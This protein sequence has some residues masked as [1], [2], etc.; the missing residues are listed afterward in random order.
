MTSPIIVMAVGAIAGAFAFTAIAR[1]L[2]ARLQTG[3]GGK[4]IFAICLGMGVLTI[5]VKA[6]GLLIAEHNLSSLYRPSHVVPTSTVRMEWERDSSQT[7]SWKAL[8]RRDGNED[9]PHLVALGRKLFSDPILSRDGRI[10]CASCH[11]IAHGGDDGQRVS[12]GIADRAGTRNAPSV[13]NAALLSRQF[14]DGRAASLEEQVYGP[15]LNPIEMGMPDHAAVQKAL[16]KDGRYPGLFRQAFGEDAQPTLD[17]AAKAIAA[18]ERTLVHES[19]YDRF[20]RGDRHALDE[21]ELRGMALFAGLGCRACH[22][23]PT[24]SSAGQT[25]P[26]G[27]FKPFPVFRDD[28]R[29]RAFHFLDDLGAARPGASTGL[30]RAPSLRNV[31]RT[32]PYFHNG[33]VAELRDAI[34]VMMWAQLGK[35]EILPGTSEAGQPPVWVPAT[36]RLQF[37]RPDAIHDRDV[38][39][40]L[41]FLESLSA[42]L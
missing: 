13:L 24:F 12:T 1:E 29:A 22:R 3:S 18:Y 36:R 25:G 34:E 37:L 19:R 32:A 21:R 41:L 35:K 23:D 40:I 8:P 27:V 10:S 17:L 28:P 15:V 6:T 26:A 39:D 2:A 33:S 16:S 11:D 31:A 20:V 14:W 30:W 42:D 7:A 38:D 9:R 4:L 5:A